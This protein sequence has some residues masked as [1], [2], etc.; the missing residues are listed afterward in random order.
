MED[1]LFTRRF[2]LTMLPSGAYLRRTSCSNA[3]ELEA[4]SGQSEFHAVF[5]FS[6]AVFFR[7]REGLALGRGGLKFRQSC[8]LNIV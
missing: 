6:R 1:L 7:I 2:F 5:N 3:A 4:A 8:R